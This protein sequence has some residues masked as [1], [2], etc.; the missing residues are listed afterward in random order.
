M[1]VQLLRPR[2]NVLDAYSGEYGH[3]ESIAATGTNGKTT[4]RRWPRPRIHLVE[5]RA[6]DVRQRDRLI[7]VLAEI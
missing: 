6:S 1:R 3:G 7:V 4:G 2:L 5:N